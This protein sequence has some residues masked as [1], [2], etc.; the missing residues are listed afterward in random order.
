[1]AEAED[2]RS[3][4]REGIDAARRLAVQ[5][6]RGKADAPEE[7]AQHVLGQR[8][9]LRGDAAK[10][11]TQIPPV[12]AEHDLIRIQLPGCYTWRR[13]SR[14]RGWGPR[15]HPTMKSA[16][17]PSA[18]PRKPPSIVQ[19]SNASTQPVGLMRGPTEY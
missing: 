5:E 10:V 1:R 16:T 12:I 6:V 8:H 11:D 14:C 13:F 17:T 9:P 7:P 4:G 2:K 19:P 18:S 3:R 15:I